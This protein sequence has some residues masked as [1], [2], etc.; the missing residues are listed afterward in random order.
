LT[1]LFPPPLS[2]P[3]LLPIY[4]KEKRRRDEIY[5]RERETDCPAGL[6]VLFQAKRRQDGGW[7]YCRPPRSI[8]THTYIYI[9]V[10][11]IDIYTR[12]K[13]KKKKRSI[14]HTA[15][16]TVYRQGQGDRH[17]IT[18]RGKSIWENRRKNNLK[19]EKKY[20]KGQPKC[21]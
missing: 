12:R 16:T 1:V 3:I 14:L 17:H 19:N 13:R 11:A 10:R 7:R 2:L 6:S 4:E 9:Y 5:T 18:K 20:K 15:H 21:L 8:P